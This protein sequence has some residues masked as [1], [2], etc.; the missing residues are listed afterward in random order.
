[1]TGSST[2]TP[3]SSSESQT[4]TLSGKVEIRI[5]RTSEEVESLRDAWSSWGGH[6]DSDIDFVLMI[7]ASYPEAIRPH[8]IA[9]YRD[10]QPDAILIGRLEKKRIPFK[11]GYV[12]TLKSEARRLNF[13]CGGLRG[14]ASEENCELL[15]REVVRCLKDDEADLALLEFLPVDSALYKKAMTI[16]GRLTR[17]PNPISQLH[18]LMDMPDSVET[19]YQ[20][21]ST[22]SRGELR[23]KTRKL[24]AH[25]AGE[26]KIACYQ[27]PDQLD[28]MFADVERV[29]RNTYQRGLGAGFADSPAVRQRLGLAAQKG[30]L[31]AFVQYLGER[32]ISFWIGC[33]YGDTFFGEYLG[34]DTEFRAFAPGMGLMMKGID[35]FCKQ[36]N[37]DRVRKLDF[38]PGHAEYKEAFSTETW[39]EASVYI[40]AASIRGVC[41][42][43]THLTTQSLDRLARRALQSTSLLPRF[44]RAWRDR[45]A[46]TSSPIT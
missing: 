26:L 34:F 27:S 19:I 7:I 20:R 12:S 44:K 33:L 22:K 2:I 8:V 32:P 43:A 28:R 42:K 16:P 31:R 4:S 5:S 6:R 11:I 39:C 13:V 14:T 45:L 38:G 1:M 37:G 9:I 35:G 18:E 24:E 17:D 15:I 25:P 41:L 3:Q 30:W 29:A 10:G 21:M 36:S 46:R 40:F 23:R